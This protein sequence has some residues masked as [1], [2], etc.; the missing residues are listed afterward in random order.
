MKWIFFKLY[1]FFGELCLQFRVLVR[2]LLVDLLEPLVPD[3]FNHSD[4]P[5]DLLPFRSGSCFRTFPFACFARLTMAVRFASISLRWMIS[6]R[7]Y[8]SSIS[9]LSTYSRTV[10]SDTASLPIGYPCTI[11]V[12]PYKGIVMY[13]GLITPE[14]F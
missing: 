11:I 12:L 5:E 13:G 14:N 3:E 8:W 6:W 2:P 7:Y 1:N 10:L 4:P 9:S